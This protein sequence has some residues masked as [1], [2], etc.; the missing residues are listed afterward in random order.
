MTELQIKKYFS[1]YG[2]TDKTHDDSTYRA[3]IASCD[4]SYNYID[5]TG[6]AVENLL[7][8]SENQ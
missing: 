7:K 1:T 8:E 5:N 3:S 6:I 2:R 4:K